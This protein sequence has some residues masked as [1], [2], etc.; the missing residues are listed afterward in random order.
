M[1]RYRIILVGLSCVL[2]A[3]CSGGDDSSGGGGADLSS[4]GSQR[5]WTSSFSPAGWAV[6]LRV[7][8]DD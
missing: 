3:G 1:I 5:L 6:T 2:A 7:V 8:F 4:T